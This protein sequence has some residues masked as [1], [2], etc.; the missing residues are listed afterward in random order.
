MLIKLRQT[1]TQNLIRSFFYVN[2]VEHPTYVV[3]FKKDAP[4]P[5]QM[6]F[7]QPATPTM[8]GIIDLHHNIMFFMIFIVIF[9][10][11]ILLRAVR[12]F[13][14]DRVDTLFSVSRTRHY[15]SLEII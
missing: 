14:S 7:Q 5:W 8:E 9:V 1:M 6:N 12:L 15:L 10:S 11:F 3:Y 2:L 4:L 13:N